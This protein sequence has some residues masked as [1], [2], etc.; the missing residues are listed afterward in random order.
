MSRHEDTPDTVTIYSVAERAGVS[1]ATVS[2]VL[3]GNASTSAAATEKVLTAAKQLN[4][5]PQNSARSLASRRYHAH[6]VVIG[7]MTGPYYSELIMGYEA[8]A[9]AHGQSVVLRVSDP[10]HDPVDDVT[11]LR[12]RVDGVL[13]AHFTADPDAVRQLGEI[14]PVVVVGRDPIPGCDHVSTENFLSATALTAHLID[15]GRRRLIFV[16]DPD[17]SRDVRDRYR[18]FVDAHTTAG[19][20]PRPATIRVPQTEEG[21][22]SAV[23]AVYAL[24]SGIAGLAGID[25]RAGI[26]GLVCANDELALALMS[27]LRDRGLVFPDDLA[28]VGWDDVTTAR[29]VTPALTTVSQ[30]VRALGALAADLLHAR[31]AGQPPGPAQILPTELVL[32]ASCGC[33]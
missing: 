28:I 17:G 33:R 9:A 5:V 4:Y 24:C 21:G 11:N 12:G 32:R 7:A 18:G 14:M 30:P 22:F 2:R 10:R 23:D 31:I 29:Y 26:D 19:L 27:G 16:G 25:G 13:M 8:A 15:H 6:A 1:I 3:R 20:T